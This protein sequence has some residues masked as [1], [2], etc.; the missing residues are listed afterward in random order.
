MD[1]DAYSETISRGMEIIYIYI[2]SV[3]SVELSI[4][5]DIIFDR[6]GQNMQENVE[7]E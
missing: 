4:Y 1:C 3:I 2:Y 5:S 6:S 7:K